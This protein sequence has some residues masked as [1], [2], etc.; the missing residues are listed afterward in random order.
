LREVRV[1]WPPESLSLLQ[2]IVFAGNL[3]YSAED[4]GDLP[5][6]KSVKGNPLWEG[7]FASAQMIIKFDP[8]PKNNEGIYLLMAIFEDCDPIQ[9]FTIP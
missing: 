7:A 3:V 6:L 2:T 5:P 9:G 4:P 1:A 8:I